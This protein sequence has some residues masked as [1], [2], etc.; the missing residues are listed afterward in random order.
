MNVSVVAMSLRFSRTCVIDVTLVGMSR[1][2]CRLFCW[3]KGREGQHVEAPTSRGISE[4]DYTPHPQ[5][6]VY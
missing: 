2:S 6:N 3:G 4:L 5:I 1:I